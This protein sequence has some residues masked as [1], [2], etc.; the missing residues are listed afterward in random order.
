MIYAVLI[1][2]LLVRLVSINQSL[3]LDETINVLAARDYGFWDFVTRYPVADFHPP[4]YFA[5]LWVWER[6]FGISEIAVRVPSVIFGVLTVFLTY[7]IGKKLFSKKVG[8]L[9]SLFL[10]VAPLHVYFSQ[11]ARMYSLAAFA[12]ALTSFFLVKLIKGERWGGVGYVL[13]VG[14]LLYSDYLAYLLL[15]VHLVWVILFQRKM[16]KS[17]LFSLVVG[18]AFILP[19]LPIFDSQL[20]GGLRTASVLSGWKDVVGGAGLKQALLL[21]VKII[22]GRISLDNNLLYGLL[23]LILSAPI[24]LSLAQL[25][26]KKFTAKKVLLWSWLIVPPVVAFLVSFWIPIF[27]YFRFIFILPAFYL[28]VACGVDKFSPKSRQ[29]LIVA[30]VLS[31]LATSG[32]Y[33][34]DNRYHREDWRGA[35]SF[36]NQNSGSDTTTLI[37]SQEIIPPFRYYQSN[38]VNSLPAFKSIPAKS[39]A[40]FNNLEEKLS[41]VNKIYLFDYLTDITDPKKLLEPKLEKLGFRKVRDYDFRGVGFV[42]EYSR[43]QRVGCGDRYLT[44]VNPVRGRDLWVDKSLW[45]LWDQ[46]RLVSKFNFPATWLLQFDALVDRELVA[47]VKKFD[48]KQEL[49]VLLEVSPVLARQ[50]RVIYPTNVAW[51][52]PQAV[53][54]SGYGQFERR[55]LIDALFN[56]FKDEFGYYPKSVGAWWIDSYSLNYLNEKYGVKVALI[57]ADQKTTDNYGVWGQWWG[58]PYYPSKSNILTPAS[59]LK[60]RQ[61]VVILQWAQR[62]PLLAYGE[63]PK[64]SNHSLQAN[65]FLSL[66]LDQEYFQGLVN[67]YLGCRNPV[68]QITVGLETGMEG[69]RFLDEYKN[70]LSYLAKIDGL[71]SVTMSNFAKE[72]ARVFP[73]VVPGYQIG[74]GS[75]V[76]K[77][78]PRERINVYLSDSVYYRQGVSFRDFF[79]ADKSGFLDRRL[80]VEQSRIRPRPYHPWFFIPA[81]LGFVYF[82]RKGQKLSGLTFALLCVSWFLPLFRSFGASGWW[83]YFGPAVKNLGA[84]QFLAVL[85]VFILVA[86]A[87]RCFGRLINRLGLLVLVIPFASGLDFLLGLARY[88]LINGWHFLGFTPDALRFVGVSFGPDRELRFVNQD[89]SNLVAGSLLKFDFNRVWGSPVLFFLVNPLIHLVLGLVLVY[90][91]ARLPARFGRGLVLALVVLWIFWIWSVLSADPR[92]VLPQ[93]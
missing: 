72:F 89:F 13:S 78:T 7:L 90:L 57:V 4:L 33:L 82:W 70:Q 80:P 60:N 43:G 18:A 44:L 11:E 3:W 5:I 8:L 91:F 62:D 45:P 53:F 42:K 68:G 35:V 74:T 93:L 75:A 85:A 37:K 66:G 21:P 73:G 51:F 40:S 49:G 14:L 77:M 32:I 87:R 28:L 24:L 54:L 55:R 59:S 41:G 47:E 34:F 30:V 39:G 9:A 15:P 50:A 19:W 79:L 22:T 17:Y 58:V 67:T 92:A 31:G 16:L 27:S 23:F 69:A 52:Y 71:E 64:Y 63:G 46:Y 1:L 25:L 61:D 56:R 26:T 76:W 84:V 2:G 10:S 65:D 83:V 29:L 6:L 12:A 86:I 88:T 48:P 38:D 20:S 36:I 81:V